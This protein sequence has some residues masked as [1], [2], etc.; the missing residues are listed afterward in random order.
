MA[1]MTLPLAFSFFFYPIT[2]VH[3]QPSLRQLGLCGAWCVQ[4]DDSKDDGTG[5]DIR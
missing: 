5:D 4:Y 1:A 2:L 3:L